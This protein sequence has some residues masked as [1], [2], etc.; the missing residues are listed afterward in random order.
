MPDV[1]RA[2]IRDLGKLFTSYLGCIRTDDGFAEADRERILSEYDEIG[3]A[4]TNSESALG[5][6]NDLAFHYRYSIQQA[7]GLDSP[8][9]A[10]II[11]RLNRMPMRAIEEVLPIEAL[12]ARVQVTAR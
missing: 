4:N 8:A 3:F 9:V 12:Q 11:R 5:S 10:E 2:T 7:G 6:M 1:S